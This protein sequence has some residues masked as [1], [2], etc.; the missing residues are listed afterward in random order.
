MH[1]SWRKKSAPW[2]LGVF[3]GFD[4]VFHAVTGAF[5]E[6]GLGIVEEAVE[7]G[8]VE[9]FRPVFEGFVGGEDEGALFVAGADDLKEQIGTALVDGEIAHFIEDEEVGF[10]VLAQ[11]GFEGSGNGGGLEI[12]DDLDG[13]GKID[14]MTLHAGVMAQGHT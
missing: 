9:E 10:G 7:Q 5:D 1:Q 12:V 11:F 2:F 6:D 4:F 14:G 8:T 3:E 13:I